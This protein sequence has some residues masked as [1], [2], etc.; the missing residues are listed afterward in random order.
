M[1]KCGGGDLD[2]LAVNSKLYLTYKYQEKEYDIKEFYNFIRN[3][4]N[5]KYEI[6]FELYELIEDKQYL[7]DAYNMLQ[8]KVDIMSEKM[9]KEVL[10]YWLPKKITEEY[11]KIFKKASLP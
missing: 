6:N 7:E 2:L 9:K 8:D 5:I 3:T 4:K 10:N 1:K 11:D